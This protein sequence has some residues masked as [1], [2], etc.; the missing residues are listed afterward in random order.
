V[1]VRLRHPTTGELLREH[2][3]QAPGRHAIP[4]H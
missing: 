4:G 2:R 1:H 3:R